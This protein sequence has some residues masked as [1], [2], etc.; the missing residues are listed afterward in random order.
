M[1]KVAGPNPV[2]PTTNHP[3]FNQNYLA[4]PL[5]LDPNRNS[6]QKP[7]EGLSAP[8]LSGPMVASYKEA[9]DVPSALES[10]YQKRMFLFRICK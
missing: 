7:I 2:R 6:L 4:E 8:F 9:I 3:V 5:Y 10:A 1:Q